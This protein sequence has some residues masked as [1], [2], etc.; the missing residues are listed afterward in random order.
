[1]R[2]M[3]GSAVVILSASSRTRNRLPFSLFKRIDRSDTGVI[4][5]CQELG[6]TL[7]AGHSLGIASK[8]IREIDGW[9]FLSMP[10]AVPG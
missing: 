4:K 6:L 3:A 2:S 5:R 9:H 10:S 7:E 1:M 8:G